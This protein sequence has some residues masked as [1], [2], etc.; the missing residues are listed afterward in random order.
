MMSKRC[1]TRKALCIVTGA[2]AYVTLLCRRGHQKIQKRRKVFSSCSQL[3]YKNLLKRY[4]RAHILVDIAHRY[5]SF[6]QC[7]I[8]QLLISKLS[9]LTGIKMRHSIFH[10][11]SALLAYG[12]SVRDNCWSQ[13]KGHQK[14]IWILSCSQAIPTYLYVIIYYS[15]CTCQLKN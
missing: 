15:F 8:R 6:L 2:T 5:D 1:S 10:R 4:H 7:S 9:R 13:Q 12:K 3:E 14:K 11:C